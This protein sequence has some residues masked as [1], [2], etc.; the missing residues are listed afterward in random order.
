[1]ARPGITYDEVAAT[2]DALIGR[3][4]KPTI[5]AIR[6]DLGTGSPNTI[7]KH[8]T[9]WKAAQAPAERQAARLPDEPA[10]ALA[11]EIERAGAQLQERLDAMRQWAQ[12]HRPDGVDLLEGLPR[13]VPAFHR[14]GLGDAAADWHDQGLDDVPQPRPRRNDPSGPTF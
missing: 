2:A 6:A 8:L 3:G 11:Q 4:E 5:G 1:M 13:P 12:R 10:S 7:H 14:Q 9:A